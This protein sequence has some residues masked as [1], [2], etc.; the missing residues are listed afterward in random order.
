M[1][2]PSGCFE[3]GEGGSQDWDPGPWRC[4]PKEPREVRLGAVGGEGRVWSR[5]PQESP[6]QSDHGATAE[7]RFWGTQVLGDVSPKSPRRLGLG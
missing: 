5:E 1:Q 3:I 7:G 4:K 6:V 2:C